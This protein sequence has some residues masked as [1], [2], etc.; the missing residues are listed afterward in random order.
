MCGVLRGG[1]LVPDA[2]LLQGQTQ[3]GQTPLQVHTQGQ[4]VL[5]ET[6]HYHLGRERDTRVDNE[7]RIGKT[8]YEVASAHTKK[9]PKN[10]V[11][12][13]SILK[14]YLES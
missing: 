11:I 5:E 6:P 4:L 10:P 2:G 9:I 3:A 8:E 14:R 7:C 1:E 12:H 13:D